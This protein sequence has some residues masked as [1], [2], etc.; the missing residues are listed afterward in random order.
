[1]QLPQIKSKVNMM[2]VTVLVFTPR[3]YES[4]FWPVIKFNRG[5][6]KA[7][8]QVELRLEKGV[9]QVINNG[10]DSWH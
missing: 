3:S 6:M 5:L 10:I 8:G 7:F 4:H 9:T 1:M 2:I